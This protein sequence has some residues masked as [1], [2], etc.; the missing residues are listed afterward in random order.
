MGL[1]CVD[2]GWRIEG[3][4]KVSAGYRFPLLVRVELG[5]ARF[6]V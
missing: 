4:G 3:S 6:V 1:S 5:L 2:C